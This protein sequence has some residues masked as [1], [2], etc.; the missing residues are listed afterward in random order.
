M[1][2]VADKPSAAVAV[3]RAGLGGRRSAERKGGGTRAI[4]DDLRQR[5]GDSVRDVGGE[6]LGRLGIGLVEQPAIRAKDLLDDCRGR[7]RAA[8]SEGRVGIRHV[9][10][11]W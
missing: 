7:P 3:G 5:V 4:C 8:R 1:R 11:R 6:C 2:G 9:K 10:A